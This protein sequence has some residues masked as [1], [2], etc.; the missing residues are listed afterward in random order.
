MKKIMLTVLALAGF[1]ILHAQTPV[2]S[3]AEFTGKYKFAAGAPVTEITV[4]NDKGVLFANSDAGNS[5]LRRIQGDVF[6]VLAYNGTATFKRSAE[7]KV[8]GIKIE[9]EDITM[10]GTKSETL[11]FREES[12]YADIRRL[13]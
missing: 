5:E 6:E 13:K 1:C 12:W 11:A 9:L 7:G 8:N 2:D 4:V 3:L 10:E